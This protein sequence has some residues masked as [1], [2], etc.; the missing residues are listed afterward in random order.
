MQPSDEMLIPAEVAEWAANELTITS[1]ED[2]DAAGE[3]YLARGIL[4][5]LGAEWRERGFRELLD[6]GAKPWQL[7]VQLIG[8]APALAQDLEEQL[9]NLEVD[10]R[11]L[12]AAELEELRDL[13]DTDED[14]RC[15]LF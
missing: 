12:T 1:D 8:V 13:F 4:S 6:R 7:C 14:V 2:P 10:S 11:A 3:I 5:L 9:T 15:K